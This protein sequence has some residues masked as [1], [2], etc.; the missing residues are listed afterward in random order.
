MNHSQEFRASPEETIIKK[1]KVID[2]NLQLNYSNTNQQMR[3]GDAAEAA[4]TA[5]DAVE[6]HK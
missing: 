4:Y 2:E 1:A 5:F 6:R 3:G